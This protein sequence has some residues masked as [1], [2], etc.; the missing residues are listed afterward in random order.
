VAYRGYELEDITLVP[1]PLKRPVEC[2]QPIVSSS[3]RGL[4]FMVRHGIKGV[5]GG[6]AAVGGASDKA[7]SA[8]RN[9]LARGGRETELGED[10]LI[11][12]STHVADTREKAMKEATPFFEEHM[13]MFAP[14][15]FVRGLT[16][17]QI[18]ATADPATA[19]K[20]GLPTI[21]DAVAA[22]SWLCG[23]PEHIVERLMEVQD[24]LP[25]LQAVN[26]GPVVSTS[27]SVILEQL[28]WLG[29]EV[30]PAFKGAAVADG[31]DD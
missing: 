25:G 15:G 7:V 22:G 27:R 11:T 10:L 14:L 30:I 19:V 16:D 23:P 29:E 6:G 12:F 5:I 24:R 17:E 31:S 18:A 28:E 8:W 26:L 1:R 3:P 20:A 21:E 4:D 13:K 2:W 9:A